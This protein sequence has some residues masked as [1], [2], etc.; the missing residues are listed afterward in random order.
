MILNNESVLRAAP[1]V[2]AAQLHGETVLLD[3][4]GQRLRGLNATGGR[5]WAL[6]DGVRSLEGV[7]QTLSDEYGVSVDR[8]R[9]DV[10]GLV[11][12]LAQRELVVEVV[13]GAK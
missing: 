3:G 2:E 1:G 7:A 11:E 6:L 12:K 8:T 5:V 13:G 4:Q 10:R 9:E